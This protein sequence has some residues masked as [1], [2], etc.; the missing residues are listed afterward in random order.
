MAWIFS[1]IFISWYPS[2]APRVWIER[3]SLETKARD[4]KL[5]NFLLKF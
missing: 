4:K 2:R 5:Q 3:L 1:E